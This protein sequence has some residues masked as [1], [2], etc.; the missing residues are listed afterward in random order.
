MS[1]FELDFQILIGLGDLK[2]Q[3]LPI[4]V[5]IWSFSWFRSAEPTFWTI[6]A[7]LL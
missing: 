1:P 2:D 5:D 4:A 6:C 3:I 7:E